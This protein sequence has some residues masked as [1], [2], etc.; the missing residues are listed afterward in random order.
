LRALNNSDG[1]LGAYRQAVAVKADYYPAHREIGR[2][3]AA[4]GDAK[5]AI[6][7]FNKALQYSPQ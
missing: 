7:A 2:I 5:G 6:D 4:K 3:L 1:A